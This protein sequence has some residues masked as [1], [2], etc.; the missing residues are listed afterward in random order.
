ME[1][2][3]FTYDNS[4]IFTLKNGNTIE[5]EDYKGVEFS[6]EQA[7]ILNSSNIDW[8]STLLYC[9]ATFD[10]YGNIHYSMATKDEFIVYDATKK[11]TI[12]VV[13]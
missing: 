10:E 7:P 5:F 8:Y 4:I 1:K 11:S 2:F 6:V 12:K 13:I 3:H 9:G